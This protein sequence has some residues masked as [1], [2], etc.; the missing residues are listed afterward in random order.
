M[1]TFYFLKEKEIDI[2]YK[3]TKVIV[4]SDSHGNQ[5]LLRQALENEN[6]AQIIFHLG[7]FYNDLEDNF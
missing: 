6:D 1:G 3:M 5:K 2:P 7:D 4:I